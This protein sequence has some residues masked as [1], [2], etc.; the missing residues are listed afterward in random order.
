MHFVDIKEIQIEKPDTV[1]KSN[2]IR[3]NFITEISF[4]VAPNPTLGEVKLMMT[5]INGNVSLKLF[6]QTGCLLFSQSVRIE[7][8]SY[9]QQ[10]DL[11]SLAAGSYLLIAEGAGMRKVFKI[12]KI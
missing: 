10:L 6:S 11:S 1:V 7:S 3:G 4:K 8:N 5:G 2:N 9:E 12:V